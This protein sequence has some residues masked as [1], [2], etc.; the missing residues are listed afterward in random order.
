MR[1]PDLAVLAAVFTFGALV[2][3]FA[4]T[5]TARHLEHLAA[6]AGVPAA[7]YARPLLLV[8]GLVLLPGALV[9]SAAL[10]S[11]ILGRTPGAPLGAIARRFV[12]SL[13]PLGAAIWLAHYGLHTLTSGQSVVP[14][15]QR[16]VM[17]IVGH[18]LIGVPLMLTGMQAG[19][20][21]PVQI[22]CIVLG[23]I[24]SMG[25]AQ[26]M[27]SGIAT[28]TTRA[29]LPWNGLIAILAIAAAWT[30]AQPM[31]MPGMVMTG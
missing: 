19:Q 2:N 18:P 14:A 8:A 20:L 13:V 28:G 27:A 3:A 17:D 29:A 23:A 5:G 31:D 4:M 11:R 12:Y 1:R 16:A 6:A 15:A 9:W 26:A 22:G 7:E 10:M 30:L 25:I 21:L 24:G